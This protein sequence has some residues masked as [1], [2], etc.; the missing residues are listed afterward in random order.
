MIAGVTLFWARGGLHV[1]APN[2]NIAH[3]RSSFFARTGALPAS[4]AARY[5]A[6]GL[7]SLLAV[8][9]ALPAA[10]P[11]VICPGTTRPLPAEGL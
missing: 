3:F 6:L 7:R 5:S 11:D 4:P 8:F 9:L 2:S 1:G 10:T